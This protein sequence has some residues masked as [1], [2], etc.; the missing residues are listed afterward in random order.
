[1]KN[2]DETLVKLYGEKALAA[3]R[4][5][6]QRAEK[7]FAELFGNPENASVFSASGR[8]EIGGN[9]T[10]H[11]RGKVLAAAVSLDVI[12][13]A[14]PTDD[15]VITVKSEGF[16]QDTVEL[17]DLSVREGDKNSS[18][19]LIRG[20]ADAF[21][22]DGLNIGGFKAYT[23]SNV[24]KGS[25]ISSSAAFEVLIGTVLSHLYNGGSVSPV[26]IAQFAQYAEN[27]HFGKP[28]G[29]MDQMASSVG[30]FIEIDFADTANPVINEISYDFAGS[31]YSLCIVDTK[32]SHADLTPEYAA[33]PPE[34][35]SVA[36]FFGKRELRDITREQLWE[37]IAEVRKACG[38]RAVSRAFHFFDE[39]GRV[40]REA[41]ALRK[42]DVEAFLREV[43][44][45]GNSSFKYLQNIFAA[46]NPKEQGM[47]LG[48]YTA[49]KVLNGRGACRVHGGGFAGTIQAFVPNDLLEKFTAETEH[50][51]GK[52][53]CY[54]LFIRPVGGTKI[55]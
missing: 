27:A 13:F 40:D 46:V 29:L 36:E 12:A 33:I 54:N 21:K 41:E 31:G 10:D 51:F 17:S 18:A 16:P 48:L 25:G 2:I 28:S 22:R 3:Q 26:K 11:N 43:T 30:G 14:V 7:A 15:G 9:H 45:S 5:R 47:V 50:L 44:A 49:E 1:M 52:G 23:T 37:N 39:N 42:G 24:L 35:K 34:M 55:A 38:D 6:Y 19:A 20:V 4:E 32:G 53:S 8:T